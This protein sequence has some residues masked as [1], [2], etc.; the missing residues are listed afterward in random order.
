V[1]HRIRVASAGESLA[2]GDAADQALVQRVVHH[3]FVGVDRAA[4]CQLANAQGVNRAKALGPSWMPA[5][6][7]PMVAPAPAP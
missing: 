6:I 5:P 2:R 4:A 3:H 1:D 7:S